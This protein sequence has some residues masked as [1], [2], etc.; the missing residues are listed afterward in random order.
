MA[1]PVRRSFIPAFSLH[2]TQYDPP[3]MAPG[4]ATA[5][6]IASR[7]EAGND[8][9]THLSPSGVSGSGGGGRSARH[10]RSMIA[11][12]TEVDET[13]AIMRGNIEALT[14]RGEALASLETRTEN[15]VVAAR[16]FRRSANKVRKDMWWKDMKMRLI[17]ALAITAV[18]GLTVMSIVQAIRHKN[19]QQLQSNNQAKATPPFVI[20]AASEPRP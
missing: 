16:G 13:V 5:P 14:N 19:K 2:G 10:S 20:T 18:V 15:L 1:N 9:N 3:T 11:A 7:L 4:P 6:I 12:Q 8:A 17:I